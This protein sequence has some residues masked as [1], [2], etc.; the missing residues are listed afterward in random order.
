MSAHTLPPCPISGRAAPRPPWTARP[1]L[2]L[3]GRLRHGTLHLRMPDGATLVFGDGSAPATLVLHRWS[4]FGALL[5]RGDIGFAEGYI[6]GD[7]ETDDLAHLLHTLARN[8]SVLGGALHGSRWGTWLYRLRHLLRRNSRA[9]SRRNIHAHYD[10]GNDFYKLWLDAS[11]TYSSAL[12]K[13]AA[14]LEEAQWAKYDRVLDELALQPGQHVLE[15]GCGWGGLAERAAR[16]GLRVDGLTLSVEQLDYAAARMA[17]TGLSGRTQLRLQ[18][19]RDW[20][21]EVD[22]VASI[23]MFEAVGEDYWPAYFAAVARAL[24]PGARA[25]IQ[26][27]TIADEEFER[28]RRST[29]FIQQYI[30]PGGMLPSPSTFREQAERAGLRVAN[31]FHFGHDYARTLQLWRERFEACLPQVRGQGFDQRFERIWRFYLAY[32]EAAFLSGSTDVVQFTLVKD[33]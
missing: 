19:Y 7:W 10:I 17:R 1:V 14:S 8:R 2:R 13:G 30:F 4:V 31:A 9:G 16:R 18:D 22:G 33:A 27:I 15:I 3:L 11:M 21:G 32:C 26:T 20:H 28:Y 5:R 6:A 25:C 24:K 23:E 12:F 29:D